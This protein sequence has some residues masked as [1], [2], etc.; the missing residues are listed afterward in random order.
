MLLKNSYI[1]LGAYDEMFL[2]GY[3]VNWEEKTCFSSTL[4]HYGVH[5]PKSRINDT[6]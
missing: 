2:F 3:F 4:L 6:I 1:I 5:K